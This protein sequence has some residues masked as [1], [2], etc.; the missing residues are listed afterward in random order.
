[1]CNFP[2]NLFTSAIRN[3]AYMSWLFLL[4]DLCVFVLDVFIIYDEHAALGSTRRSVRWEQLLPPRCTRRSSCSRFRSFSSLQPR[5]TVTYLLIIGLL[6]ILCF[7]IPSNFSSSFKE[8]M[9]NEASFASSFVRVTMLA[10]QAK[11]S[12][13]L[14]QWHDGICWPVLAFTR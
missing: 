4:L 14:F 1:M 8:A 7:P 12:D 9:N 3:T 10:C 11:A 13:P 2:L 6:N 5:A